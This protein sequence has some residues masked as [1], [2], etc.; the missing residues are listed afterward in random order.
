MW[1][2]GYTDPISEDHPIDV[3]WGEASTFR[4]AVSELHD[5]VEKMASEAESYEEDHF[6]QVISDIRTILE[7]P[8][9]MYDPDQWEDKEFTDNYGEIVYYV[10][11]T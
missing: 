5:M 2:F 9:I 10:V 11:E 6:G 4:E 3:F 1:S 7:D 8:G